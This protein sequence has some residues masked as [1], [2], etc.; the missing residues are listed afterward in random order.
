MN[1]YKLKISVSDIA[2]LLEN[3]ALAA[4]ELIENWE[5]PLSDLVNDIDRLARE[6]YEQN[7]VADDEEFAWQLWLRRWRDAVSSVAERAKPRECDVVV[8]PDH[9]ELPILNDNG[10]APDGVGAYIVPADAISSD[11]VTAAVAA[12]GEVVRGWCVDYTAPHFR[13]NLDTD[14]NWT[15]YRAFG[16]AYTLD[17]KTAHTVGEWCCR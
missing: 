5:A 11:E 8:L 16:E 3:A 14:S 6:S 17:Y 2:K 4:E 7:V 15:G 13:H 1:E 12:G 10:S 9:F